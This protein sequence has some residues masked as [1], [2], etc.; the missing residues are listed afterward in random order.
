MMQAPERQV[1]AGDRERWRHGPIDLVIRAWGAP[2]AVAQARASAWTRF[3][4]VLA[5]LVAELAALK[6]PVTATPRLHG[7][8]A[9]R[10]LAACTPF[11]PAFITPMA[12]VAGCVADDIL[13][14]FAIPGVVRAYVNNG[15][16]IAIHLA[17][18]QALNIGVIPDLDLPR[19]EGSVLLAADGPVRGIATS[20][21]RGRSFSLGIADSVTVLAPDAGMADAAAT[22]IAN[23]VDIDHQAVKRRPACEIKDDSDLGGRLV[24][25]EV[26]ALAPALV[27]QALARGADAA[28]AIMDRGLIEAAA[29][30]LQAQ[31]RIVGTHFP[32]IAVAPVAYAIAA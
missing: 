10:M 21:W 31:W 20:G 2:D 13:R 14:F 26:G 9:R 17:P 18:R 7:A 3:Q 6:T 32:M 23:A 8:L 27:A 22:M 4:G 1:L 30:T 5:E 25:V 12:A 28:R 29:L 19:I 24:T 11:A 15:G 16:D